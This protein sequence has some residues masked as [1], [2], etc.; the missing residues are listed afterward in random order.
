MCNIA[1]NLI[2]PNMCVLIVAFP[3]AT[4]SKTYLRFRCTAMY[5]EGVTTIGKGWRKLRKFLDGA[6]APKK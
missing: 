6:T 4:I 2:E 5:Y 3:T 1:T